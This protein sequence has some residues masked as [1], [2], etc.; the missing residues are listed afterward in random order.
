MGWVNACD[1]FHQ[2]IARLK[3]GARPLSD[4]DLGIGTSKLPTKTPEATIASI[5]KDME[6]LL[7]MM[8]KLITVYHGHSER[9]FSFTDFS[10]V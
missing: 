10:R 9:P 8:N 5:K 3:A 2:E 1:T 6:F 7:K 4:A